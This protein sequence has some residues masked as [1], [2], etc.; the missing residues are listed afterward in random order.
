MKKNV[1][2]INGSPRSG[3]NSSYLAKSLATR[4]T[5]ANGADFQVQTFSPTTHTFSPC[6]GCENCVK[7]GECVHNDDINTLAEALEAAD[8]LIWVTPLYFGTVTAQLKAIIDRFQLIWSRNV[9]AGHKKGIPTE[10][11]RPVLVLYLAAKDDPF[12]NQARKGAALIPLKYASNTAGFTLKAH[13][14]LIGPE[15]R[16]DLA[17]SEFSAQLEGAVMFVKSVLAKEF[18]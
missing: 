10:R 5:E 13:H 8:V 4:I 3:G 16:A 14:A 9:L 2:I 18:R 12:K 7:T 15:S 1:V 6:I 11:S 17:K